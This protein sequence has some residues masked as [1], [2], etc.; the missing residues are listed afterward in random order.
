VHSQPS[1]RLLTLAVATYTNHT[2]SVS[3]YHITAI[4]ANMLTLLM[5]VYLLD[6]FFHFTSPSSLSFSK[7]PQNN[8]TRSKSLSE[9]WR[10]DLYL[11]CGSKRP[12][13]SRQSIAFRARVARTFSF[14]RL[15][16]FLVPCT[17]VY[18]DQWLP[19][20]T[21]WSKRDLLIWVSIRYYVSVSI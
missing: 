7:D 21:N 18:L 13:G 3:G 5:Q 6:T 19:F 2:S 4:S 12:T 10:D 20:I 16:Y 15:P 8:G 11:S 9:R 17:L 1:Y 14:H